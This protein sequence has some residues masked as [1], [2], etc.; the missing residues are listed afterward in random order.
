MQLEAIYNQ[1]RLEFIRPVQ[2]KHERIRLTVDIPDEEILSPSPTTGEGAQAPSYELP[3]EV[4]QLAKT[5]EERLNHIRNAPFPADE[6][7]PPLT[8]KQQD[9][10]EASAERD[11]IRSLR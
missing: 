4:L 6:E 5:M 3:P 1:G 10:I 9:R 11:E 8:Q 7:L 2:L